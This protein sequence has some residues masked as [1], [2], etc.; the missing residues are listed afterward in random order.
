MDLASR[1]GPDHEQLGAVTRQPAQ[2]SDPPEG[3]R[4]GQLTRPQRVGE[5]RRVAHFIPALLIP[6]RLDAVWVRHLHGGAQ[7]AEHVRGSVSAIRRLQHH[8]GAHPGTGR[9]PSQMLDVIADPGCLQ[10]LSRLGHPD[11]H[12]TAPLH[13]HTDDRPIPRG[14]PP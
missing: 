11:Q 7:L 14:L 3:P 8:L 9:H 10:R 12:R 4:L 13:S 6:R 5:G 2:L 1:G